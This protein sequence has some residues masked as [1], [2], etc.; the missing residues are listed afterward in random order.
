MTIKFGLIGEGN[1]SRYHKKAIEHVGGSSD[2]IYDPL[3]YPRI[4]LG[5]VFLRDLDFA[6]ICSPSHCHYHQIKLALLNN[7]PVI[8]EKPAFLPWEPVIDDDRINIVMQLREMEVEGDGRHREIDKIEVQMIRDRAYMNSWRGDLYKT[9]GF[10][11][12]LFIHYIDLA[13]RHN[14]EFVGRVLP[15]GEN[16][17]R[18]GG[19]DLLKI[20]TQALYNKMYERTVSGFGTKP[21]DIFLLYWVMQKGISKYGPGKFYQNIK[22]G[23]LNY[24]I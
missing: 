22:L 13:I 19:V 14:C 4:P 17:R 11:F 5:P 7:C 24:G 1:I 2:R 12:H 16:I 10:I 9:G 15:Q 8:V 6:V 21:K 3:K 20:D 18:V 23:G